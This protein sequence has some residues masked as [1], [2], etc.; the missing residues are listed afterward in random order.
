MAQEPDDYDPWWAA[1]WFA[2]IS[3]V[4]MVVL[5]VRVVRLEHILEA[6]CG[7]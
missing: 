6:C 1:V 3:V 2:F 7:K 4:V 5:M